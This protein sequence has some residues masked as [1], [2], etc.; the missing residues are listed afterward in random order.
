MAQRHPATSHDLLQAARSTGSKDPGGCSGA[1]VVH[2]AEASGHVHLAAGADLYVL[3]TGK[4]LVA[5]GDA[6]E[7]RHV[8]SPVDLEDARAFILGGQQVSAG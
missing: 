3:G 2:H 6:G 7:G 1:D 5:G 8:S 4:G